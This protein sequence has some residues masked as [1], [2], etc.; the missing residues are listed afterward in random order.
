MLCCSPSASS[1]TLAV[2]YPSI[3]LIENIM[4]IRVFCDHL[5]VFYIFDPTCTVLKSS[6]GSTARM[7]RLVIRRRSLSSSLLPTPPPSRWLALIT[8]PPLEK[9]ELFW[10]RLC[11]ALLS[12]SSIALQKH[13][14]LLSRLFLKYIGDIKVV[15]PST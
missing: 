7:P 5:N 14:S 4:H 8:L 10:R 15:S 12:S 1:S 11:E 2:C 13:H 3:S 9:F 6:W